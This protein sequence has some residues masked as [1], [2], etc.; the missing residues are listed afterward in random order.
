MTIY[1]ERKIFKVNNKNWKQSKGYLV[2]F[3]SKDPARGIEYSCFEN[4]EHAQLF[5]DMLKRTQPDNASGVNHWIWDFAIE[6]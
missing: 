4:K 2:W 5:A 3:D 6:A 1:N